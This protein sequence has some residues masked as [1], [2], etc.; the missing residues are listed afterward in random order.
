MGS[1]PSAVVPL[2][3][4]KGIGVDS[5]AVAPGMIGGEYED[6]ILKLLTN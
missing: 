2:D 1:V 4:I 3:L 6:D 5:V